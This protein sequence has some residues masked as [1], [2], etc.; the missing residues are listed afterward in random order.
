M[1]MYMY[2]YAFIS[3]VLNSW[4]DTQGYITYMYVGDFEVSVSDTIVLNLVSRHWVWVEVY[5]CLRSG[6]GMPWFRLHHMLQPRGNGHNTV[7]IIQVASV[8]FDGC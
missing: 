3:E 2:M 1:C 6:S 7:T 4:I 8:N 5:R